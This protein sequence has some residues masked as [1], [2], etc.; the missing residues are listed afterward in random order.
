M[1]INFNDN[2]NVEE[3]EIEKI[4]QTLVQLILFILIYIFKTI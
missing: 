4:H 2:Y 1:T 3:I